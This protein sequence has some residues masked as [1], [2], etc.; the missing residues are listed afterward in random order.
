MNNIPLAKTAVVAVSRDCFPIGLSRSRRQA[1]CA[2]CKKRGMD[3]LEIETVIENEAQA[4]A[5]LDELTEKGIEVL[6]RECYS[7]IPVITVML[8]IIRLQ[9]LPHTSIIT[10]IPYLTR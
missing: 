4:M 2:C 10:N 7:I 5:V 3:V 9:D 8:I 6:L 1:V